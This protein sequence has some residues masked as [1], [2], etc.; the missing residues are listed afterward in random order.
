MLLLLFSGSYGATFIWSGPVAS[1][2]VLVQSDN[3]RAVIV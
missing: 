2:T 3:R 1:R